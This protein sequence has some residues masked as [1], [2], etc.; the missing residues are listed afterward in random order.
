MKK[1][2]FLIILLLFLMDTLLADEAG[3]TDTKQLSI[4]ELDIKSLLD[5]KGFTCIRP[6]YRRNF[7]LVR[8]GGARKMNGSLVGPFDVQFKVGRSGRIKEGSIQTKEWGVIAEIDG[9]VKAVQTTEGVLS[10]KQM[11]DLFLEVEDPWVYETSVEKYFPT[12]S[13][14]LLNLKREPYLS[15]EEEQFKKKKM[16][17]IMEELENMIAKQDLEN[18]GSVELTDK[19]WHEVPSGFVDRLKKGRRKIVLIFS[20]HGQKITVEEVLFVIESPKTHYEETVA[21]CSQD[22]VIDNALRIAREIKNIKSD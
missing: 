1:A 18:K 17:L 11:E 5:G 10:E 19:E 9:P 21:W 15:T 13:S 2:L 3:K 8:L 16:E 12:D 20:L 4:E 22:T 6:F 7:P 14:V